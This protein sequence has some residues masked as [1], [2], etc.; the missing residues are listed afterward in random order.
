MAAR[1]QALA[2]EVDDRMTDPSAD[3]EAQLRPAIDRSRA[4]ADALATA[5]RER[6]REAMDAQAAGDYARAAVLMSDIERLNKLCN[7]ANRAWLK[8]VVEAMNTGNS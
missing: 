4:K 7:R 2:P 3:P 5:V 8:L 6:H 1:D